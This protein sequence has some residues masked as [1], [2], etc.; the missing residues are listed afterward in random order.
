MLKVIP[1][2][3]AL[4]I[5]TADEAN[6]D[7]I[8]TVGCTQ[9]L[10]AKEYEPVL[11]PQLRARK[12]IILRNVDGIIY[13]NNE[14][15]IQQEIINNN[16][17]IKEGDVEKIYKFPRSHNI[18]VT[19][20][21]VAQAEKASE[22][23]LKLFYLSIPH[24]QIEQEQFTPII[25][26]YRCYAVEDH[27]AKDCPKPKEYKVCSLCASTEHTHRDCHTR[28]K[29]CLNCKGEHGTTAMAC[30]I[31][32]KA[33]QEKRKAS[34]QTAE[35][36]GTQTKTYSAVT[37]MSPPA[38]TTTNTLPGLTIPPST[39]LY[40]IYEAHIMNAAYPGTYAA[41]LNK[42]FKENGIPSVN[43]PSNPPS[44]VVLNNQTTS[45][46]V[47]P[48][49]TSHLPP[50]SQSESPTPPTPAEPTTNYHD[51]E[52]TVL[53]AD[54]PQVTTPKRILSNNT[55]DSIPPTLSPAGNTTT[56]EAPATQSND[57]TTDAS[58]TE[59]EE[60]DE[61]EV[62]A[63]DLG[64]VT[65]YSLTSLPENGG[66]IDRQHLAALTIASHVKIE[67]GN[68]ELSA[69]YVYNLFAQKRVDVNS[70][71]IRTVKAGFYNKCHNVFP[72][73]DRPRNN[74]TRTANK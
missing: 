6:A 24:H 5:L 69:D 37:T 62:T 68:E 33:V 8:F 20:K 40:C 66:K 54:Q 41:H 70:C 26:C 46:T 38:T 44:K 58:S 29:Q 19:F 17:F 16:C 28:T 73:T 64:G 63:N 23:G 9:D 11:P 21:Q 3:D 7:K 57:Y 22:T 4:I 67:Y 48:P 39:I 49:T 71:H 51:R 25:T 74:P 36:P 30:P 65:I 72:R 34:V 14:A 61:E 13:D 43:A 18:K 47:T 15:D 31:R 52:E 32:K 45:T 53:T 1:T 42:L 59:E 56:D 12:S 50:T 35:Q 60:S 55:E 10:Q 27:V 2:N